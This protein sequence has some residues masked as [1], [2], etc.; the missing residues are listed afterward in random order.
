MHLI[1]MKL[2]NYMTKKLKRIIRFIKDPNYVIMWTDPIGGNF[3]LTNKTIEE[4]EELRVYLQGFL[5][6]YIDLYDITTDSIKVYK[7]AFI[8]G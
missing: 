8:N 5:G 3:L 7:E 2:K 1:T 4:N 6:K